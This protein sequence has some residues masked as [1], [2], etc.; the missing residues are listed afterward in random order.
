VPGPAY[1]VG[2]S[3]AVNQRFAPASL[4]PFARSKAVRSHHDLTAFHKIY[5]SGVTRGPETVVPFS[6]GRSSAMTTIRPLRRLDIQASVSP[7]RSSSSTRGA[8][9]HLHLHGK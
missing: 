8:P 5:G 6:W 2:P 3:S 7:K 4:D 9:A 1:R